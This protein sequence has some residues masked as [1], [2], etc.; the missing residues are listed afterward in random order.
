MKVFYKNDSTTV[1]GLLGR[2]KAEFERLETFH[3]S[4]A[5]REGRIIWES[6][7]ANDKQFARLGAIQEELLD[8]AY[9]SYGSD[10]EFEL[11]V[12]NGND[13]TD[14]LEAL[15]RIDRIEVGE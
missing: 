15:Q 4:W 10:G 14:V 3:V 2:I 12:A 5:F 13:W 9:F 1:Q 11:C 8:I 7:F 6:S